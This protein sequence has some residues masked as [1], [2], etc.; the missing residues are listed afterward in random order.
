MIE[1]I[2]LRKEYPNVVP[3]ENITATINDGE[4][5]SIIGPSGTGKSTLLR[6]I[7]MLENPTSGQ[8]II[9]GEEI[10]AAGYPLDALRKKAGMVFQHFNLFNHMTVIE[11]V[12]FAPMKLN[13]VKPAEAYERGMELLE[14]VGM[15]G[16]AMNYPGELSGGQK[17]R[18]AI[19]RTLANNPEIILFD[20]PTSALDPTMVGEVEKVIQDLCSRGYTIL[21]VTHDMK[22][23]EKISTRVLY[24]D[25]GGV[26]EDGTPEQIFNN[27]Q[28]E[29]TKM[30]IK[31]SKIIEVT[32]SS[33]DFD[34]ISFYSK[35]DRFAFKNDID[36]E[37]K[38][39][40]MAI[41]EE[42]CYQILIPKLKE[43]DF[44]IVF[45][46]E[47]VSRD[48]KSVISLNY[49]GTDIDPEDVNDVIAW[50]IIKH[51]SN[52]IDFSETDSGRKELKIN[53]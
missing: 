2:N 20:E 8:I 6:L 52:S 21:L 25:Q 41:F 34:F 18:V 5:V 24:L 38:R 40:I 32:L 42:L 36:S 19:A 29:R 48:K 37:M 31:Q 16:W 7:N 47:Y 1:L 30:F 39:K 12:C 27:P 49:D 14:Q 3:I 22:F 13:K 17:Q 44:S 35:L 11:N 43:K 4:V 46:V 26:Y 53:I 51:Y 23:A 28:K 9:D 15:S 50:N 33:R 45:N 10:T